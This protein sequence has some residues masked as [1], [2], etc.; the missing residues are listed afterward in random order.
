MSFYLNERL[1]YLIEI[2]P[3]KTLLTMQNLNKFLKKPVLPKAF[4][5]ALLSMAILHEVGRSGVNV[6]LYL[7]FLEISDRFKFS[8]N[9]SF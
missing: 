3:T 5:D 9:S 1:F 8:L 4:R 7:R 6:R 2:E